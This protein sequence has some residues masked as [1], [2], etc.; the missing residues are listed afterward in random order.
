MTPFSL[1]SIREIDK[2]NLEKMGG[3]T[4]ANSYWEEVSESVSKDDCYR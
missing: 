4:R 3:L 2:I 1:A